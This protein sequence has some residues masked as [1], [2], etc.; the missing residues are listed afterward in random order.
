MIKIFNPFLLIAWRKEIIRSDV[1][2]DVQMSFWQ[3]KLICPQ[4]ETWALDV[5]YGKKW[6]EMKYIFPN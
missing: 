2:V 5:F 6:L 1:F 4:G 3:M